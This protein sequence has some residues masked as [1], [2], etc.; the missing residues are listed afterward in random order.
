MTTTNTRP[1]WLRAGAMREVQHQG[2]REVRPALL[3]DGLQQGP[4]PLNIYNRIKN[5]FIYIIL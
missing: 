2:Q 5:V 3:R 4:Q 1:A